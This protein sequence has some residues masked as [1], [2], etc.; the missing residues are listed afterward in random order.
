MCPLFRSANVLI[1][2]SEW[3]A[4]VSTAVVGSAQ[5]NR[6]C[7]LIPSMLSSRHFGRENWPRLQRSLPLRP[8][9]TPII[10]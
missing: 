3:L 8:R 5:I 9:D 2:D 10:W 4:A 7:R 6:L 1:A